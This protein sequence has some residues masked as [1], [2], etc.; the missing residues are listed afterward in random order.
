MT[1]FTRFLSGVAAVAATLVLSPAGQVAHAATLTYTDPLCTSFTLIPGQ[2][3]SSF[4]LNC[5]KLSCPIIASPSASVLPGNPITLSASCTPAADTYKW[6]LVSTSPATCP[7]PSTANVAFFAFTA[8][9]TVTG[10]V[11]QLDASTTASNTTGRSTVTLS[12]SV[13]PPAAPTGCSV[14]RT[15]PATGSFTSAGGAVSLSASCATPASGITWSWKKNSTATA[16]TTSTYT[17]TLPANTSTSALTTSY[18]ATACNGS[19]CVVA[20]ST[21]V[22]VAG[23]SSVTTGFCSQ[24]TNVIQAN[25]PWNTNPAYI[26]T[27]TLSGGMQAGGVFVG[28]LVIPA[29]FTMPLNSAGSLGLVEYIDPATTRLVSISTQACDFRGEGP[30]YPTDPT[31]TSNP[32]YWAH[33]RLPSFTYKVTGATT[34]AD[35]ALAPGTY[36]VNVRNVDKPS[37]AP[38]ACPNSTCNFRITNNAPR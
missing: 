10:C 22:T 16:T 36:Y 19:S 2:T 15:A 7:T 30:A 26:D 34:F 29:G 28:K 37:F 13:A 17:E 21:T 38:N 1:N 27:S 25:L 14:T 3:N 11:Y 12:W 6:T 4:T 35:L 5:N 8:D 18:E 33:D 23:T 9:T 32:I 31:G 20:G 24:Y